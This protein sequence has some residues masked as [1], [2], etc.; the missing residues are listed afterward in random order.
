MKPSRLVPFLA[1]LPL[2]AF[3]PFVLA[4]TWAAV[5]THSEVDTDSIHRDADGLVHYMERDP[6]KGDSSPDAAR[7][8][9]EEAFDCQN[10]ISFVGLDEPD[11]KAQGRPV[12]P[13]THGS[14]LMDF[15]CS[16]APQATPEAAP[17]AEAPPAPTP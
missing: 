10:M 12:N 6:P 17:E 3:A 2:F 11:W 7:E 1:A 16:R 8:T 4:E 5:G 15:V 13:N 9:Y 14:D